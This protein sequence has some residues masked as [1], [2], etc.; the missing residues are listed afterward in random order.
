MT[1]YMPWLRERAWGARDVRGEAGRRGGDAP[2]SPLLR[3]P[4]V[5]L[6]WNTETSTVS[7][8][9]AKS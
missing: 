3:R 7:T 1:G 8:P 9:L 5:V 6:T 2:R 4:G